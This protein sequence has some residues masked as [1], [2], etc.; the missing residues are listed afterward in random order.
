MMGGPAGFHFLRPWWLTALVP[1]AV[2][3]FAL[4]RKRDPMRSYE[5]LVAPHLLKY[6]LTGS[7]QQRWFRPSLVF[8]PILILMVLALAGPSWRVEPSPFAEDRAGLMILIKVGQ[9]MKTQDLQP[10]RLDRARHKLH[11]LLQLRE[12]GS[13][14]LIAYSGSA[15]VVMPLTRDGRII[16]QMAEALDPSIMPVEGDALAEALDLAAIQ[17]E[18]RSSVGSILV[19]CDSVSG[20]QLPLLK[21][22]IQRPGMPVQFL[23]TAGS[24]EAAVQGGVEDAARTLRTTMQMVTVDDADVTRINARSESIISSVAAQT[25]GSRPKDDGY[26]LLPFILL[27]SL[28][29][30]RKGWS[31]QWE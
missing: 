20:N 14:G 10:S 17:F 31:I 23:V 16:E 28:L 29:W 13:V 25:E 3:W 19:M 4:R 5:G 11:D 1:A 26:I 6:L 15:H 8:L 27:G 9:T 18:A 12:S 24:R 21:E 30:A 22:Y 2:I 7:R